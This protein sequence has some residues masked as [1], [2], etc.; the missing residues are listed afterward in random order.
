VVTRERSPPRLERGSSGHERKLRAG[1]A[2][3]SDAILKGPFVKGGSPGCRHS[4]GKNLMRTNP[5]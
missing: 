2:Q 1:T 3:K 5:D 4:P